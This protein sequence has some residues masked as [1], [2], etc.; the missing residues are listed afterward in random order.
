MSQITT[1]QED[2]P[3]RFYSRIQPNTTNIA[4]RRNNL[5]LVRSLPR[6]GTSEEKHHTVFMTKNNSVFGV[7]GA[8]ME[9]STIF[10]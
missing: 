10:E 4:R 2:G 5:H 3:D 7:E 8:S 6:L 9:Q 1:S